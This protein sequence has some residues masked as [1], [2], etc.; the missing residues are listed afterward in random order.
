[1]TQSTQTRRKF[2][3][4]IPV[5]MASLNGLLSISTDT[6]KPIIMTVR[7]PI[8]PSALG[9]TL[10]HEHILVDFIGASLISGDRWNRDSVMDTALPFLDEARRSG[11][12]SFV[13]CTPN[14][15]GRDVA[16]LKTLSEQSKL[17]IITNTGYYGVDEKFLPHHA[18]T[19][20]TAALAARWTNE[21]KRGIDN[22]GIKPGFIKIGVNPGPLTDISKKLVQ[23]AGITHLQTGLTI[24]SHTGLAVGAFEQLEL[25][26]KSGVH[27]NA[28]IWV[29]AQIETDP[30]LHVKA[31][32]DGAWISLDNVTDEN[33]KEYTDRLIFLKKEKCLDRVLV[34][35]DAGWYD[36]QKSGGGN[37]RG[38]TSL[39]K[40]LIPSLEENGFTDSEVTRIVKVNPMM[41]FSLSAKRHRK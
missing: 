2:L 31:A 18:F 29:H 38:F 30:A 26:K 1:M 13:D 7:G 39:F 32:K 6:K 40:K 15:L 12:S 5:W 11:F 9:I 10:P 23:A 34:S 3:R 21:W 37:F 19:E 27:P 41:A 17:N 28:F 25:L 35:H 24:A 20:T 14:Y 36:P 8:D 22:T 4:S 33:I 16:L